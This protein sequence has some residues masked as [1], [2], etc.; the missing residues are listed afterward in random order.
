MRVLTLLLLG[1]LS[2]AADPCAPAEWDQV[3]DALWA[4]VGDGSDGQRRLQALREGAP[5]PPLRPSSCLHG[6][7]SLHLLHL[8]R[9][10]R[11]ARLRESGVELMTV[12]ME[13]SFLKVGAQ[14]WP[15]FGLLH[16]A[17]VQLELEE[18][19]DQEGQ[20]HPELRRW[21]PLVS[22]DH[23][24]FRNWVHGHLVHGQ[25][26]PLVDSL[27]FLA[28]ADPREPSV[29]S[30]S[31]SAA[32]AM[33]YLASALVLAQ[34]P[35][36]S[37]RQEA[38]QLVSSAEGHIKHCNS[39]PQGF[40]LLSILRT[41]WPIWW[42]LHAVFVHLFPERASAAPSPLPSEAL[43]APAL[44][45]QPAPGQRAA[46]PECWALQGLQLCSIPKAAFLPMNGMY[47][48]DSRFGGLQTF[49]QL[50]RDGV[51]L[52]RSAMAEAACEAAEGPSWT[53]LRLWGS[54]LVAV[55]DRELP[56][57]DYSASFSPPGVG[58]YVEASSAGDPYNA[59]WLQAYVTAFDRM[60]L[61]PH[62]ISKIEERSSWH[63]LLLA[64]QPDVWRRAAGGRPRSG[65]G[66]GGAPGRLWEDGRR[67]LATT[68]D[69]AV[70]PGQA[71]LARAFHQGWRA[72]S[73]ELGGG[74]R[75]RSGR[76]AAQGRADG[77]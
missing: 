72:S 1:F 44:P 54:P 21:Q 32:K 23:M 20:D 14:R 31:C 2:E 68:G 27:H 52:R 28:R 70:L 49:L 40:E 41:E 6:A 36:Q 19:P 65:P 3:R 50:F 22:D 38:E 66:G 15:I 74:Q 24:R 4:A 8:L 55:K 35:D 53:G 10:S 77:C 16:L 43:S 64:H 29:P 17:Q 42:L 75:P 37:I 73:K 46:G 25:T 60:G 45:T 12:L 9:D 33:G 57:V 5:P 71:R 67:C 47:L 62:I 34:E 13:T 26:P 7:V 58:L 69:H 56:S 59:E 76:A 18:G 30:R 11:E 51:P 39:E 63:P 61:Q 48:L